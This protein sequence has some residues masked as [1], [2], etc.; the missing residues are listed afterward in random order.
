MCGMYMCLLVSF[1]SIGV[2]MD[3]GRGIWM[4]HGWLPLFCS[5]NVFLF[6]F[7][8]QT[9][10]NDEYPVEKRFVGEDPGSLAHIMYNEC[11]SK[12]VNRTTVMEKGPGTKNL[13]SGNP[14]FV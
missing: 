11:I 3:P 5:G 2:G 12:S 7:V 6:Y 10:V 14:M 4:P 1:R 13:L 8:K 9:Q